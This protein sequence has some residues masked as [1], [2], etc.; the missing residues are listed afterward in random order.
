MIRY[1]YTK[2]KCYNLKNIRKRYKYQ[3]RY[4]YRLYTE[5]NI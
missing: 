5:I 4:K 1:K 2:D 3:K